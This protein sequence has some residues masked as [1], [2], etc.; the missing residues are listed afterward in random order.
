MDRARVELINK[1][2]M[3]VMM[4]RN[5]CPVHRRLFRMTK[6]VMRNKI[7]AGGEADQ[8]IIMGHLLE[9]QLLL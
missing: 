6:L 3:K 5:S 4:L 1:T 2:M 9:G 7:K 8:D